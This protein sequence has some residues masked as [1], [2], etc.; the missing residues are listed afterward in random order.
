MKQEEQ[1]N[2]R[3]TVVTTKRGC[4]D[5]IVRKRLTNHTANIVRDV[6]SRRLTKVHQ[7]SHS[8]SSWFSRSDASSGIQW[9]APSICS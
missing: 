6:V 7:P 4:P 5:V 1:K 8:M 2:Q 3:F 9:L